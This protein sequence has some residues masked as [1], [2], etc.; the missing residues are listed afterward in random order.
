MPWKTSKNLKAINQ[1]AYITWKSDCRVYKQRDGVRN[2]VN[3][4]D[5]A[6]QEVLVKRIL[7]LADFLLLDDDELKTT[8]DK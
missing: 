6:Q 2:L 4:I 7:A 8:V 5:I 3:L 1:A